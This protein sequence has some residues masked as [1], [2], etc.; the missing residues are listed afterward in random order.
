ML[1]SAKYPSDDLR[2]QKQMDYISFLSSTSAYSELEVFEDYRGINRL[3]MLPYAQ[4]CV[5]IPRECT[6]RD[7]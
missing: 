3:G 2:S 5:K 6:R 7:R 1:I 4:F